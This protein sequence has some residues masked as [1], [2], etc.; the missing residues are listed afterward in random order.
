MQR[1]LLLRRERSIYLELLSR[2]DGLRI[3]GDTRDWSA[4]DLLAHLAYRERATAGQVRDFETGAWNRPGLTRTRVHR[5]NCSVTV[6]NRATPALQ[7]REEFML[8]RTEILT[9]VSKA[10]EE[11]EELSPLARIVYERCVLHRGHHLEELRNWVTQFA[12]IS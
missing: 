1:S 5:I 10:P 9:V 4:K 2:F 12:G 7:L 8:A 3:V 11:L 6:A